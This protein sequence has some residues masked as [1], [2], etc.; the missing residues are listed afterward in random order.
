MH[1]GLGVQGLIHELL[2]KQ[3]NAMNQ[4]ETKFFSVAT[5]SV[6]DRP[7]EEVWRFIT[8][9]G[10]AGQWLLWKE[11]EKTSAGPVG[12]GTTYRYLTRRGAYEGRVSEWEPNRRFTV[13]CP[14]YIR[15]KPAYLQFTLE[16]AGKGTRMSTVQASAAVNRILKLL[17]PI[18]VWMVK[19]NAPDRVLKGVLESEVSK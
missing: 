4:A 18:F 19:R 2:R 17:S 16:P 5:S 15:R 11:P 13:Y 7:V 10:N 9:F 8:D 1:Q 12:L 14:E 3:E 6:I